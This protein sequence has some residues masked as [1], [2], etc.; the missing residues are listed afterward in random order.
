MDA[1]DLVLHEDGVPL[2]DHG[3]DAGQNFSPFA[4]CLAGLAEILHRLCR[5]HRLGQKARH[6]VFQLFHSPAQLH[7]KVPG[8]EVQRT[9]DGHGR[10]HLPALPGQ[11]DDVLGQLA[12]V[13][14]VDIL[15]LVPLCGGDGVAGDGQHLPHA[16]G[17]KAQQKGLGG[18]EV[19]VA[20]GHVGQSTHSQFPVYPAGHEGGIHP[21]LCDGAVGDGQQVSACGLQPPCAVQIAAQVGHP[22]RIQFNGDDLLTCV[23]F[24]QESVIFFHRRCSPGGK[25]RCRSGLGPLGQ[26]IQLCAQ[27]RDVGGR[28]TAAAA[29]NTDAP[30]GDLPHL[31]GKIRRLALIQHPRPGDHRIARVGH[32]RQGQQRLAKALHQFLHRAGGRDAVQAHGVHHAALLHPAQQVAEQQALAG[33]AVRQHREGHHDKG[34]RHGHTQCLY[35]LH[36]AHIG[37]ERLEQKVLCPQCGELL[38]HKAVGAAGRGS[39]GVRGRA[40]VSEDGGVLLRSGI[41]GQLPARLGQLFPA[42]H[43]GRRHPGQTEG[44]GLDGLCACGQI[45]RM[46]LLHALGV[47]EVGHFAVRARC[48]FII[49]THAAVEQKRLVGKILSDVRH[50]KVL[51]FYFP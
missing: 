14:L 25:L 8:V 23:Q 41:T 39:F 9:K 16:L 20:A 36:N 17:V 51:L 4:Q 7:V 32:H 40:K 28:R 48:R 31:P 26:G 35:R 1:V 13:E 12:G 37:A 29:Q 34:V 45:F 6:P 42:R 33:V 46:D 18:V 2:A 10:G 47:G 19:A 11:R 43:L 49:G 24:P 21:G 44:V 27:G 22:G 15:H 5:Q 38:R 50:R 30:S 3:H